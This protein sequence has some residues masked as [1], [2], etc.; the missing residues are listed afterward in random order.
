MLLC[1]SD[2]SDITQLTSLNIYGSHIN[3]LGNRICYRDIDNADIY[4]VKKDGTG[5]M[6]LSPCS[7][8]G[9]NVAG[10]WIIFESN[11]FEISKM[12]A[13]GSEKSVIHRD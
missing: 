2:I 13:D 3:V 11:R 9:Y 12:K 8:Y 10:D 5:K 1:K 4:S 7:Y 6:K